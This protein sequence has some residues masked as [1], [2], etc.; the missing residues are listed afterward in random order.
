M[1]CRS[2]ALTRRCDPVRRPGGLANLRDVVAPKY[3][4]Q[5]DQIADGLVSAFAEGSNKLK[6]PAATL[7]GLFTF[8]GATGCRRLRRRRDWRPRS[9][10]TPP[11]IRRRAATSISCATAASTRPPT[12]PTST[13]LQRGELHRPYRAVDQRHDGEPY[14]QLRRGLERHQPQRLRQFV[15]SWLQSRTKR[16]ATSSTTRIPWSASDDGAVQRDRRQSRHRNT[17]MLTIENSY[18]T[19]AKLLTTVNAMF[20]SL[21]NAV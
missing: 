3:G 21:L 14:V 9:R 5:L 2:P 6:P 20:T 15:V 18:T 4:A 19:T 11:S 13:I 8:P 1:A 12:T 16:R 10:S 7:P 17:N